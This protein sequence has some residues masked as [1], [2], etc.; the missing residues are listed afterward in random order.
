MKEYPITRW[1]YDE[2]SWELVIYRRDRVFSATDIRLYAYSEVKLLENSY[3]TYL[4]NLIIEK[5]ISTFGRRNLFQF[6]NLIRRLRKDSEDL[7]IG[8]ELRRN[9]QKVKSLKKPQRVSINNDGNLVVECLDKSY[10]F[11]DK[12]DLS[13]LDFE[14]LSSLN[15]MPIYY[16][17]EDLRAPMTQFAGIIHHLMLSFNMSQVKEEEDMLMTKCDADEI[18]CGADDYKSQIFINADI[19]LLN[20]DS[21]S[22]MLTAS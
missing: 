16:M 19:E 20:A 5:P 4:D 14:S 1:F 11:T 13:E 22:L 17:R 3:L 21:Q 9:E 8:Y 18:C 10:I 6:L 15:Q 12:D 2:K 7:F